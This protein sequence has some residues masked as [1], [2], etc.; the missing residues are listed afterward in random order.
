MKRSAILIFIVFFIATISVS[1]GASAQAK[2]YE[3]ELI[4][5]YST[6]YKSSSDSRKFNVQLATEKLNNTCLDSQE[7]FS[8]NKV[9]GNRTE[10]NGYRKSIVIENGKFTE[11]VGGGVC[12]VSTTL[13]NAV[14]RA[15]LN[16]TEC[17]SHSLPVSYVELG[18][19]AMVST[20]ADFK[21][22]N[23]TPYPIRI[24]AR[25]DG[26][27]LTVEIYGFNN[28]DDGEVHAFHSQKIA[29]VPSVEY[30]I[31]NEDGIE[32]GVEQVVK[33]PVPGAV[34]DSY[35]RIFY[36]NK[37][38]KTER[39]RRTYYPPQKGKKRVVESHDE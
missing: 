4:G 25:A 35:R 17:H 30:E 11:G 6:S 38:I 3:G 27:K 9:I 19:D 31:L 26:N 33:E 39:I 32:N 10:E 21:F 2:G 37:I 5:S 29:D 13:Y 36:R 12:Q 34:V 24:L 7:E 14:I 28:I 8:F 20:Y 22:V 23:N 16:V 15:V 1:G 18:F